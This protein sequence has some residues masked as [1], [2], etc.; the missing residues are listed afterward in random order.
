MEED[1]VSAFRVKIG[2]Y[3]IFRPRQDKLESTHSGSSPS[4]LHPHGQVPA[5]PMTCV[6][7]ASSLLNHSWGTDDF[8]TFVQEHHGH[9]QGMHNSLLMSILLKAKYTISVYP[10]RPAK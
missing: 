1:T 8:R 7:A 10:P 4:I 3:T 2:W 9:I 6:L 5:V